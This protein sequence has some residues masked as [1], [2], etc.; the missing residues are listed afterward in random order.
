MRWLWNIS[1]ALPLGLGVPLVIGAASIGPEEAAS[2]L[3]KWVH[4]LGLHDLPTWLSAKGTDRNAILGAIA[5]AIVYSTAVFI[6]P[7]IVRHHWSRPVSAVGTVASGIPPPDARAEA[8]AVQF[9]HPPILPEASVSAPIAEVP[10]VPLPPATLEPPSPKPENKVFVDPNV[11]PEFL[12]GLYDGN[13]ILGAEMKI[14]QYIGKWLPVSGRLSEVMGGWDLLGGRTPA[15][16][17]FLIQKGPSVIMIF[18]DEWIDRLAPTPKGQQIFVHGTIT[19]VNSD[20]VELDNCE[21]VDSD[22][23]HHF[24]P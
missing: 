9:T 24:P 21:L 6:I 1:K 7:R 10:V 22:E 5:F 2:N 18:Q 20:K 23:V 13:T 15:V 4:S 8:P 17:T 11:T 16:A 19:K 12:A 3:S 14:K